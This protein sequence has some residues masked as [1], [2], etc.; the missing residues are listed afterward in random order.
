[1]EGIKVAPEGANER[2]YK[3]PRLENMEANPE[4]AEDAKEDM[5]KEKPVFGST[6][7]AKDTRQHKL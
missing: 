6:D 5:G 4:R 7:L 2:K 1:M 3:D